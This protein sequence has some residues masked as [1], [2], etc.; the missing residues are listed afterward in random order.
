[1]NAAAATEIRKMCLDAKITEEIAQKLQ[2]TSSKGPT[3]FHTMRYM[4]LGPLFLNQS[5]LNGPLV[6]IMV[7][8]FSSQE[9]SWYPFLKLDPPGSTGQ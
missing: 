6:N 8:T 5:S 2:I 3:S 9:T 7:A 4:M 1:M